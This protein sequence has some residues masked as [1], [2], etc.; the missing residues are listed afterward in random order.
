MATRYAVVEL[1]TT[2]S[3]QDEARS[4]FDATAPV[5]VV[6]RHQ[7]AGRGRLGRVWDEPDR[8]LFTSLAL[9]PDWPRERWPIIPLVA[10]LAART[11]IHDLTGVRVE[12][13]WPNDLVIDDRKVGG[14]LAESS[15]SVVVVGCGVNLSWAEPLHDATALSDH[16]ALR[17]GPL[18]LA[19]G[20]TDRLLERLSGHPDDWGL[21]DY[22]DACAT[23]GRRVAYAAGF[24]TAAGIDGDGRL[25]V[26]TDAGVVAI[27]S[28]EVR[29]GDT[30]TGDE[31]GQ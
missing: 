3:T 11:A 31:E 8:G 20:W 10:G 25:L 9:T 15:G 18:E 28:G 19:R 17:V 22:R 5:L 4:R 24:G 14:L 2:P 23:V 30:I 7:T 26:E 16:G 29:T 6:S 13:R 27:G 21:D 1:D 12:L